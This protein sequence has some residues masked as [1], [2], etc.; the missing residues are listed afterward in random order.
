MA[1]KKVLT[2][3]EY[4]KYMDELG[5]HGS[6]VSRNLAI[7]LLILEKDYIDDEL[8][9]LIKKDTEQLFEFLFYIKTNQLPLLK[10]VV[11]ELFFSKAMIGTNLDKFLSH[12]SHVPEIMDFFG[13]LEKTRME[14][15]AHGV[16]G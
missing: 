11:S 3:T 5:S 12:F 8:F 6:K 15:L 4:T 2:Q 1:D 7:A 9:G 10:K 13:K 16:Y 14:R